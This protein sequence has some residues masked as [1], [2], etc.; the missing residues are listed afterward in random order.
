M[1]LKD[2]DRLFLVVRDGGN[3]YGCDW[4]DWIDPRLTGRAGELS[5]LELPWKSATTAWGQVRVNKN[6][7]GGPL[8]V[9]GKTVERGIGTHANSIIEFAV[10]EGFSRFRARGGLDNGGTDQRACGEQ[11]S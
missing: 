1:D 10:P 2:A 3:G 9:A 5:L 4:A 11:S 7:A 6:A 8:R